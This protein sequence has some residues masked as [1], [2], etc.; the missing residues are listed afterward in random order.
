MDCAPATASQ[1]RWFYCST[2]LLLYCSTA[3]LLYTTPWL[4]LG[5]TLTH[6]QAP[7]DDADIGLPPLVPD[8]PSYAL[9][10]Q[11]MYNA[12]GSS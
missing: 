12:S 5:L 7:A 4:G 1:A 3:L 2:A 9:L 8:D 10:Y 6:R 11:G